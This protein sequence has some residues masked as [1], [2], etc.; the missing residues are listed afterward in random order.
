MGSGGMDY[1]SIGK[2]PLDVEVNKWE[3]SFEYQHSN[4]SPFHY[5]GPR[6]KAKPQKLP[7]FST[8]C[9]NSETSNYRKRA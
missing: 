9:R 3:T 7:V 4:I 5:S 1:W 6:Q 2:N 8:S